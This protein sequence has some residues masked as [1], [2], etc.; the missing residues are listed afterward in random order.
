MVASN[1]HRVKR[2]K[3]FL[4]LV[5]GIAA[6]TAFACFALGV[7]A[8]LLVIAHMSYA[9]I[10]FIPALL[11]CIS[12]GGLVGGLTIFFE[13]HAIAVVL[14]GMLGI[15]FSWLAIWLPF[16]GNIKL[17]SFLDPSLVQYF[18][19]NPVKDLNQFR[20]VSLVIVGLAAILCGLLEIN[21]IQQAI[22]SSNGLSTL[23]TLLICVFLFGTA[24]SA[25]DQMI[26]SNLREPVQVLDKLFQFAI[27]NEGTEVPRITARKMHFSAINQIDGIIQDDRRLFLTGYDANLGIVD[28][29]VDF[30]GRLAKCTTI[31]A[32]PTDCILVP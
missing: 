6:G 24:G 9:W 13:K 32:Q 16:I 5:Y 3:R 1:I 27:E 23:S 4:G 28:I 29:L 31:Y 19:F 8:L 15:I 26:N 20:L 11:I 25:T 30:G 21:L 12:A 14:W 22:L 17:L 7:D 10:K 2:K 18:D